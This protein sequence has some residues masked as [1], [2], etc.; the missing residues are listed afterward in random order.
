MLSYS[1]NCS[2]LYIQRKEVGNKKYYEGN[3][4]NLKNVQ[5]RFCLNV[6]IRKEKE[7]T[8]LN[9]LNAIIY[10]KKLHCK[11]STEF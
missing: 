10:T 9:G 11:R 4:E 3:K 2:T 6:D 1:S 8:W 7:D 5:V